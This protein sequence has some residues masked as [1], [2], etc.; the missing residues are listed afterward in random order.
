ME[1]NKIL[2]IVD[3]QNDFINGS[4]S[5]EGAEIKMLKLTE[6][7]NKHKN[8]Y[9]KVV[10]TCDWHPIN[11]ISFKEWPVH[12]VQHT[13]G[14]A[15]YDVLIQNVINSQVPYVILTKGDSK[16]FDEYSVMKNYH[17]NLRLREI[18]GRE[19]IDEIDVC[20]IAN[21]YC[22]NESVK[23]IANEKSIKA[24]MNILI[25]YVA[26]IKD[27]SVLLKTCEELKINVVKDGN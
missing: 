12:C 10:F 6:F 15:I 1:K 25:D 27:E 4:L 16:S 13:I 20:G 24:N 3:A 17:S 2:L 7:F 21:E 9:T 11:H 18:V 26:A 8:E 5:V 23:D 22:V 19:K 14:A